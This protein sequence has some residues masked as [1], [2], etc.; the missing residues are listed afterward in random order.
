VIEQMMTAIVVDDWRITEITLQRTNRR[1]TDQIALRFSNCTLKI[2][3]SVWSRKVFH[4]RVVTSNLDLVNNRRHR[5]SNA[6]AI[7]ASCQHNW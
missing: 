2:L 1:T 5:L 3:P 7:A 4:E 6:R